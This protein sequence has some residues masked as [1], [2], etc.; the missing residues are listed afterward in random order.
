MSGIGLCAASASPSRVHFRL[1]EWQSR[2]G[3]GIVILLSAEICLLVAYQARAHF[4][5]LGSQTGSAIL[6]CMCS[7]STCIKSLAGVDQTEETCKLL[8]S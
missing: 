1:D 2:L 4:I 8:A 5:P 6:Q 3:P 7:L